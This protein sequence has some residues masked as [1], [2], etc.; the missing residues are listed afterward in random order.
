[1]RIVPIKP[2]FALS[3]SA[4]LLEVAAVDEE[5]A[6][7]AVAVEEPVVFDDESDEILLV[8]F[9]SRSKMS[10]TVLVGLLCEL[11]SLYRSTCAGECGIACQS[12]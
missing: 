6:A 4:E 1:M 11:S 8:S 7:A 2:P 3:T 12:G 5:V 9:S 10:P